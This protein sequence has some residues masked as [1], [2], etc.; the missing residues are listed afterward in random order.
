MS[1]LKSMFGSCLSFSKTDEILSLQLSTN[2]NRKFLIYT[3]HLSEE[4]ILGVGKVILESYNKLDSTEQVFFLSELG[5][6]LNRPTVESAEFVRTVLEL[7]SSALH[8]M[9]LLTSGEHLQFTS[10]YRHNEN[11]LHIL[12]LLAKAKNDEFASNQGIC[13]GLRNHY[14]IPGVSPKTDASGIDSVLSI[15]LKTGVFENKIRLLAFLAEKSESV[16]LKEHMSLDLQQAITTKNHFKKIHA[17]YW[18]SIASSRYQE[19]SMSLSAKQLLALGVI[20]ESSAIPYII[21]ESVLRN[22]AVA[23]AE[24]DLWTEGDNLPISK[25]LSKKEL[26]RTPNTSGQRLSKILES[27]DFDSATHLAISTALAEVLVERGAS[28]AIKVALEL[29]KLKE[30]QFWPDPFEVRNAIVAMILLAL[31]PESDEYPFSWFVQ[32]SDYGWLFS[33]DYKVSEL[34]LLA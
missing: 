33:E 3:K 26:E 22:R 13:I 21:S 2:S 10:K 17:P 8:K 14:I 25:F 12:T 18:S 7:Q 19:L 16:T 20:T 5:K 9:F 28:V 15:I 29:H 11:F 31:Q 30:H 4:E 23:M 24:N 32:F 6:P 34:A 1:E 27:V